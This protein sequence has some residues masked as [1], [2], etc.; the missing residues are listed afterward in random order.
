MDTHDDEVPDLIIM[1]PYIAGEDTWTST[2]SISSRWGKHSF[3]L[4]TQAYFDKLEES[5]MY[6]VV[7]MKAIITVNLTNRSP[8]NPLTSLVHL[9]QDEWAL[10]KQ[11]N[12]GTRYCIDYHQSEEEYKTDQQVFASATFP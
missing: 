1:R 4:G 6:V 2:L 11:I 12:G 5:G 3:L 9:F 7:T 10:N 8:T